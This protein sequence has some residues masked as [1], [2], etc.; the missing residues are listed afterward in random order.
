M[1][2]TLNHDKSTVN[3]DFYTVNVMALTT[4][5]A[6]LSYLQQKRQKKKADISSGVQPN[7]IQPGDA[8][9]EVFKKRFLQVYLCVFGADWLQGPYI[10]PMYKDEKGLS[11]ET[12]AHLFTTG[13]LAAAVSATFVGSLADRYGRRAAC[14]FFC[15]TYSASC[16][17]ILFD[18]VIV[19]FLG[20]VLGGISTTLMY[21]VFESWMVTEYHCQR[22][23]EMGG[24]LN[25]MFGIMTTLN[26][27]V[28]IV[29]GLFA[30]CISDSLG[31]QKAPFLAA[32]LCLVLAFLSISKHWSE[33]YGETAAH[34]TFLSTQ[35]EPEKNGFR[36]IKEDK[37]LWALGI[38]SCFFEGSMYLWIFFKF[39]ALRLTH[40]L[41]GKGTDLPFG[42]IFAALMCAMMLGSMF[43]TWYTALPAGRWV[44]PASN[45]L[46]LCL[47]V[48]A[49]CFLIPVLTRDEEITFWCFCVFEI[50]VGIYFPTMG[51][52]KENIVDDGVRA[53]VY[54][55]LR[56]PLN[57]FV[58]I[59]LGLTRE[60]ERHR[61]FIF[62][63]CGG[64][65]IAAGVVVRALMKE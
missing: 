39:P 57:I 19:L 41:N 38:T 6:G 33:N 13:F 14:R 2:P 23:D 63:I 65:L 4:L 53:K 24:S 60:G 20:R 43:F 64:A 54:G 16:I 51:N 22:L 48:A 56:V 58:V 55:I 61:D 62:R 42:T 26:S 50:C 17:T 5:N 11:E 21:S 18:N 45:L 29:A 32:V 10:Y 30:Q 9:Y 37:R 3:L 52:L 47:M 46:S 35:G 28:A 40:Q 12:V 59:G 34:V 27:V 49:C 15:I 7:S 36:L 44:I 31:T 1:A 25:D 8:G